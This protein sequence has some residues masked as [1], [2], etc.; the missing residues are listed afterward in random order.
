MKKIVWIIL[1]L[2]FMTIS[3]RMYK[4]PYRY[5]GQERRMITPE[6]DEQLE[7]EHLKK[8]EDGTE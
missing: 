8:E 7:I 3:C 6:M 4:Y 2:M 1:A 5:S